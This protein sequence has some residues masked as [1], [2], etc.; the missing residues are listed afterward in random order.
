M[1]YLRINELAGLLGIA[2]SS[3]YRLVEAGRL[4]KPIYISTRTPVFDA[5]AVKTMIEMANDDAR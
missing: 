3:V 2:R 5:E 4:P 1:Q